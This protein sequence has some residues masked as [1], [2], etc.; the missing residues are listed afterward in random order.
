MFFRLGY[1]CPA[2]YNP[3]DYFVKILSHTENERSMMINSMDETSSMNDVPLDDFVL[4]P[5]EK[6]VFLH[7]NRLLF[8]RLVF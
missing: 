3:A 4:K 7:F 8:L 5:Y 6:C 1:H 2:A